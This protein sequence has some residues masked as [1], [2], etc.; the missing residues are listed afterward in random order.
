MQRLT[1]VPRRFF[2]RISISEPSSLERLTRPPPD[3]VLPLP[4]HSAAVQTPA[5]EVPV[6]VTAVDVFAAAA[7]L[8][9]T[10]P[11]TPVTHARKLSSALGVDLFFKHEQQHVTGSFKERGARNAL[12]LLSPEAAA[13]GV[14]AASAGNHALALAHHGRLCVCGCCA[15]LPPRPRPLT[16]PHRPLP[17]TWH[18]SDGVHADTRAPHEGAKLQGARRARDYRG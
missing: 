18:S 3:G 16:R 9:G 4:G 10:L 7:R 1:A 6:D 12:M 11:R 5:G 15:R 2:A 17:Q 13:R 8:R 14:A